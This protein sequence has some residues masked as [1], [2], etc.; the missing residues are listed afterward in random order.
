MAWRPIESRERHRSS[1]TGGAGPSRAGCD[2]W[3]LTGRYPTWTR[4]RGAASPGRS[5]FPDVVR[6]AP[7]PGWSTAP[8]P[9]SRGK[10]CGTSARTAAMNGVSDACSAAGL[11]RRPRKSVRPRS[12]PAM[13]GTRRSCPSGRTGSRPSRRWPQ[14]PPAAHSTRAGARAPSRPGGCGGQ[15]APQGRQT[16]EARRRRGHCAKHDPTDIERVGRSR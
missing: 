10:V 2:E 6:T 4:C 9:S 13:W 1:R 16:M 12:P 3:A 15:A 7:A 14:S 5:A 8:K 11:T